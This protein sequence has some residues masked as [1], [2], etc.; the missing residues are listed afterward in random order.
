[1]EERTSVFTCLIPQVPVKP[2]IHPAIRGS[3][4]LLGPIQQQK[5]FWAAKP[6]VV[7]PFVT[8]PTF[9]YN[10]SMVLNAA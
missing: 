1:M 5:H 9:C 4:F 8:N 2:P 10:R 6:N 7:R 3:Y